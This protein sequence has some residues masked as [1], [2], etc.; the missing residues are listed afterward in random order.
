M[1]VLNQKDVIG[2][3]R[4]I[5]WGNGKSYRMLVESDGMGYSIHHTVVYR[6]TSSLLEYKNHLESA[7]VLSGYGEIETMD[8]KKWPIGPGDLYVLDKHDK[9][10]LKASE[11]QDMI[12]LC[13][14]NPALKGTENHNLK[15][16]ESSGY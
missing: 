10:Y 6:G 11:Q 12:I 8:G 13:V 3:D 2:T 7:Y 14:F 9:H 16:N 1:K 4:D 5:N 15:D